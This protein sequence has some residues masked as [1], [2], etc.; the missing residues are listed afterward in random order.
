M[1]SISPARRDAS[2]SCVQRDLPVM[3][4]RLERE[5]VRFWSPVVVV[6]WI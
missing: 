3:S 4:A 2:S 1:Q 5:V 6:G